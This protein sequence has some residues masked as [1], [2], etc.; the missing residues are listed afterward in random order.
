MPWINGSVVNIGARQTSGCTHKRR[1]RNDRGERQNSITLQEPSRNE[2]SNWANP[3]AYGNERV[4]DP[5]MENGFNFSNRYA[6]TITKQ[7]MSDRR[8]LL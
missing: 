5:N 7:D 2:P 4:S 1:L 6:L 3:G 8:L